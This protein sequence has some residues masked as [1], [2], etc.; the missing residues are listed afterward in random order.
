M[1]ESLLGILV[2]LAGYF[3]VLMVL[4]FVTCMVSLQILPYLP[5][6]EMQGRVVRVI[7]S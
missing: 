6:S 7:Y 4:C 3:K 1:V 2:G 5:V